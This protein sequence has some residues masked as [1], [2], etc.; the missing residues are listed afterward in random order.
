LNAFGG[1]SK[2]APGGGDSAFGGP[3]GGGGGGGA[4]ASY[5]SS[6]TGTQGVARTVADEWRKAGMS[7][8][9]VAGLMANINEESRFDPTLRHADQP[10]WGGEAHFAHGLYQ[11]GGQE[12]LNY[13]KWLGQNHP[14]ADEDQ[15]SQSLRSDDEGEQGASWQ[16]LRLRLFETGSAVSQSAPQQI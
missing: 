6:P 9:G 3:P 4:G 1:Y 14:G 5:S 15:L 2:A 16:C 13:E 8:A 12:W 10:R 11:E 7:E